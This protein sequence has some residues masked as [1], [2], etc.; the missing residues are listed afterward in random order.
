MSPPNALLPEN[1]LLKISFEWLLAQGKEK[2]SQSF[3]FLLS[4]L[5]K[6]GILNDGYPTAKK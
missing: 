4:K 1:K 2:Y 6:V 5:Y 3:P